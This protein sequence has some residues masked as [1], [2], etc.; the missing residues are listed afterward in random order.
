MAALPPAIDPVGS[1][2][3]GKRMP[4]HKSINKRSHEVW[5]EE[6]EDAP[7]AVNFRLRY[8]TLKEEEQ[9]DK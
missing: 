1:L 5:Y 4:V 9:L 8:L 3:F 6:P 7:P 2:Q